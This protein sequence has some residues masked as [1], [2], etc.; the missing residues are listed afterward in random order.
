[1]KQ[2]SV[3]FSPLKNKRAFDEVCQEIKELV[4]KG[5]IK[6]GEKLP[7]EAHLAAQFQVSRQTIRE[8]L[9]LLELSGFVTIMRGANGGPVVKDTLLNRINSLFLDAFRMRNISIQELT[10]ARLG[11]EKMILESVI[12]NATESDINK[13]EQN[14]AHA[15]ERIAGRQLATDTNLEFHRL[16][17][18]ASKNQVFYI[19]MGSIHA[20][21]RDYL[22]S[23]QSDLETSSFAVICH[24]DILD[25]L[26][27]KDLDRA[28]SVLQKL[29]LHLNEK[30]QP[31]KR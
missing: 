8:A 22:I 2:A 7:S 12:D 3:L 19:V 20:V 27:D 1:M 25:A 9:R 31:A 10:Q 26:K 6:P 24:Q 16:L 5:T 30:L 11:I 18:K 17:A 28:L 21:E 14:L 13:L 23:C 4:L 15:K 29:I